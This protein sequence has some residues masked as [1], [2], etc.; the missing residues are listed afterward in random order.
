M[1]RSEINV[2]MRIRPDKGEDDKTYTRLEL[3]FCEEAAKH[4]LLQL[5]GHSSN[6][7]L[8]VSM[9]NAMPLEGVQALVTF[10]KKFRKEND[11]CV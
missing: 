1:Y 3:K 10:M 8:R 5:K 6:P 11:D 9:Y 2:V 7:G 4:G